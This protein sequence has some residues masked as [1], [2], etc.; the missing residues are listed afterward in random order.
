MTMLFILTMVPKGKSD[1]LSRKIV[2]EKLAGCSLIVNLQDSKFF[3]EGKLTHEKEDL[4]IF[5]TLEKNSE[6]I[7]KRIKE[8]HPYETPFI[9]QI[10][11]D[12]TNT[13]YENWLREVIG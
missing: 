7:F 12:K 9:G 1:E 6:K 5:K 2:E 11:L 13:E 10:K 3:W 8:L 4:I